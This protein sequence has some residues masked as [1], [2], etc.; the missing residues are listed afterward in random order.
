MAATRV[1]ARGSQSHTCARVEAAA[2]PAELFRSDLADSVTLNAILHLLREI[3]EE[4]DVGCVPFPGGRESLL[5]LSLLK[6]ASPVL[7]FILM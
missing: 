5:L 2:G 1:T 3:G 4:Q 7:S 6:A